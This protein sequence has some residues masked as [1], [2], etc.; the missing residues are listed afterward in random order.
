MR[1]R[2]FSEADEWTTDGSKITAQDKLEAIRR[3]LEEHGPV[4]L[5]HWFYRGSCA[6][7]RFVFNDFDQLM[8][9]LNTAASAGD[10]IY[11]WSYAATCRDDNLLANG[12]CPDDDGRVP[13]KGAY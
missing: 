10:S 11:V 2:F 7:D 3:T 8:A 1:S 13:K 5:E 9:H 12:K 6:P 4:I